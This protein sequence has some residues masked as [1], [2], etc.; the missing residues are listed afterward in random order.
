M[1]PKLEIWLNSMFNDYYPRVE[2]NFD[3]G[4]T[5]MYVIVLL[6]ETYKLLILYYS[7]ILESRITL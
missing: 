7:V 6:C 3:V 4:S 1:L 5:R 2:D